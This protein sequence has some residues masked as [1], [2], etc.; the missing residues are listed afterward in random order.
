MK[1]VLSKFGAY[2]SHLAVLSQDSS[3][4]AVDRAKLS[5]YYKKWVDAKYILG[6]AVFV[7]LLA[8]CCVFSKCM[9]Q[10]EVD[11]LGAMTSLLR[12]L[13]EIE[14]LISK[15]LDQWPTYAATLSK[16]TEEDDGN[17]SYQCQDLARFSEAVSFYSSHYKDYCSRVSHCIKSRLSWSDLDF[18]RDVIFMLSTHGWEK[19]LEEESDMAAIQRLV[20]RF[21]IPLQGAKANTSEIVSEFREMIS[22]AAQYIALSTLEYRS[23]WWKLFHSPSSKEWANVLVLA[24]LLFSLPASNGKLERVF[25]IAGTIKVDKRSLLTNESLNDLLLL[26]SDKIP[27]ALFDPNPSIDL[28]WSAKSQRPSQKPRKQYK[29]RSIGLSATPAADSEETEDSETDVLNDWDDLINIDD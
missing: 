11:I 10:D 8:P 22:Y 18:V 16:C 2:T 4:K 20:D 12:T 17:K 19:A 14:K 21:E 3:V 25:S 27:L 5:G 1:R 9:Q 24:E 6:C 15:P 23:V 28:W 13:K 29:R 7:D 26:N